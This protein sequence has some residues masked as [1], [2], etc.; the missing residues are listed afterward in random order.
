ME[1]NT[2]DKD[3]DFA[4]IHIDL[5]PDMRPRIEAV[6]AAICKATGMHSVSSLAAVHH[7]VDMALK[8]YESQK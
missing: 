1:N 7:L 2:E 3:K 5:E 4:K 8:I 6:K